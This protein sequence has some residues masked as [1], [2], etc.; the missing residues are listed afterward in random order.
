MNHLKI[1]LIAIA[2]SLFIGLHHFAISKSTSFLSMFGPSKSA[3]KK[4]VASSNTIQ[5]ALLLDTSGSMSGLIEQAKSQ[6]WK[7]L[8]ELSRTE[9]NGESPS[10]QIALY[11]YGNPSKAR[12]QNQ[13]HKLTDFTKDMDL[14]SQKLFALTTDGGEEYC[15]QVIYNSLQ[16]LEWQKSDDQDLKL[17]YIAGNEAFSQGAL[18]YKTACTSA[19]N[20]DVI[21]NTIFCG[22]HQ[23]GIELEWQTG[24]KEGN[25]VYMSINHNE[26]TVYIDSPY[27]AKINQ[28]NEKLNST[29]IPF[30]K[31]GKEK[32]S[33]QMLQD[34]NAKKYGSSNAASRAVFKSKKQYKAEKWD[35]VDAYKKDKKVLETVKEVPDSLQNISVAELEAKIKAV[36]N[37]R[38]EIQQQI[39][40]LDEKR[41][42]YIEE[43]SKKNASK[44][45]LENSM[46]ESIKTQA[47]KKGYK[48]N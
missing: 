48:V 28:L 40:E 3:T 41:R 44:S 42:S 2:F 6:L 37:S 23:Q 38:S 20:Q 17:I 16:E 14:I 24:A 8:N 1:S 25:G 35:L 31:E 36:S 43:E 19:R 15:G 33:N 13:I 29:Y 10:L 32:H 7:I 47:A 39:N 5:V 46:L 9:K 27:D 4:N 34:S 21:I 11:E 45:S 30:G 22:D 18:P 26:E 12:N